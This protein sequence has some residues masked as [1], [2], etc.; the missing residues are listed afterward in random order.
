MDHVSTLVAILVPVAGGL[1]WIGSG[2]WRIARWTE[3]H[4]SRVGH[5]E[6]WRATTDTRIGAIEADVTA[7]K[8]ETA[9]L[10]AAAR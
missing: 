5:L 9:R 4:D 10:D 8:V 7:L 1:V 2:V 6:T 3:R